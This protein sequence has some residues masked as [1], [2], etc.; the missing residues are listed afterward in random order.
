MS[1]VSVPCGHHPLLLKILGIMIK[2]EFPFVK[3]SVEVKLTDVLKSP[4]IGFT[5]V[6]YNNNFAI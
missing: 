5:V 2:T 4:S 3:K 6:V 1:G